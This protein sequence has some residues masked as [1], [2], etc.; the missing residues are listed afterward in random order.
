MRVGNVSTS[1]W[2][3]SLRS[4]PTSP[5]AQGGG[6]SQGGALRARLMPNIRTALGNACRETPLHVQHRQRVLPFR[7]S[8]SPRAQKSH[9]A[10]FCI[11]PAVL[12]SPSCAFR[13][14]FPPS[15]RFPFFFP[16]EF[17]LVLPVVLWGYEGLQAVHPSSIPIGSSTSIASLQTPPKQARPPPDSDSS[18]QSPVLPVV[19]HLGAFL[20]EKGCPQVLRNL[21]MNGSFSLHKHILKATSG[22][23]SPLQP[24]RSSVHLFKSSIKL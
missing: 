20:E 23:H 18:E 1:Q 17:F 6:G 19:T 13:F 21:C 14:R 10:F 7:D 8:R 9:C 15:R 11:G 12:F 22:F 5:A 4:H 24:S 2:P 3:L 16:L